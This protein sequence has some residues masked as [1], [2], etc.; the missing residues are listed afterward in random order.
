R[1]IAKAL[2]ALANYHFDAGNAERAEALV[3]AAVETFRRLDDRFGFAVATGLL[4]RVVLARGNT[5]EAHSRYTKAL[6]IFRE[7]ENDGW[8]AFMSE[9]LGFA[10]LMAEDDAAARRAYEDAL[11]IARAMFD[12]WRI[13]TCLFGFAELARRADLPRRAVRL[14]AAAA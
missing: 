5:A 6:T 12:D 7:L 4:G 2:H 10:C 9:S 11:T 1:G 3:R 14:F 8:T 13:A